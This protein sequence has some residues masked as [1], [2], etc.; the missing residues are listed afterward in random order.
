M[1]TTFTSN[2]LKSWLVVYTRPRWEK[3]VDQLLQLQEIESFC[4]TRKVVNQ[5]ADRKKT[6]EVP[7]FSSYV[8]VNINMK[9]EFKVR[10]T[11]GVMN[12]IYFMGKPASVRD[13][14]IVHIKNY[15]LSHSD[16][17]VMDIKSLSSGDRVKIRNG[18]FFNQEGR[19]LEIQGK[20]VLLVLDKLDCAL[21]TKVEA[22]NLALIS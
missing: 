5:W 6:V 19:V 14:E 2:S 3:K 4:P 20:K 22:S 16:L 13:S 9:D 1:K 7:L 15:L 17:E 10:Q 11:L 8:F 21:V 18:A 12:F